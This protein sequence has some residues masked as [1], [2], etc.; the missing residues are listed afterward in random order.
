MQY[1]KILL[2][3]QVVLRNLEQLVFR[4]HVKPYMAWQKCVCVCVSHNRH[5][6]IL[7]VCVSSQRHDPT[8]DVLR[9]CCYPKCVCCLTGMFLP[10]VCGCVC[11]CVT[12]VLVMVMSRSR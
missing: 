4:L 3:R 12:D 2:G 9:L 7:S 1:R 5:V 8:L 11:V 10:C 6:A